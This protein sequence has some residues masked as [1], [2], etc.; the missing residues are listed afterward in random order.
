ML[1][2]IELPPAQQPLQI[3]T[4]FPPA[5]NPMIPFVS[6]RKARSFQG[7]TFAHVVSELPPHLPLPP[8]Q[9]VGTIEQRHKVSLGGVNT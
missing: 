7:L 9:M 3:P 1:N 4:H 5:Q 6:L 8:T 2:G